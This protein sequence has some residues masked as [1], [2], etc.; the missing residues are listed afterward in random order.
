MQNKT[1]LLLGGIALAALV[2]APIFADTN[3]S[4]DHASAGKTKITL[5]QARVI[6][7]KAFPGKIADSELEKEKGGS[8]QRYSFDIKQGKVTQEVGVDAETGQVLEN[9]QEGSHPD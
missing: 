9:R 5:E 6:A 1:S 4:K 3:V 7:L 2:A 8:G